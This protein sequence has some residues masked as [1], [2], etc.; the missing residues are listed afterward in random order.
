MTSEPSQGSTGV[1][2][3]KHEER[4]SESV[5]VYWTPRGKNNSGSPN[6]MEDR[7]TGGLALPAVPPATVREHPHGFSPFGCSV[8]LQ[9]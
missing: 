8:G 3:C 1:D 6:M 4:N 5:E 2:C 7:S 9:T